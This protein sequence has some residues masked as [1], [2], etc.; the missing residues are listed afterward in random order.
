MA[1]RVALELANSGWSQ[2]FHF[3]LFLVSYI[4]ERPWWPMQSSNKEE[5]RKRKAKRRGIGSSLLI[6]D[7]KDGR[8]Q[9]SG[10]QEECKKFHKLHVIGMNVD[11]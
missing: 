1:S 5:R 3:F 2:V 9:D 6:L 4:E 11:L 7:L 10:K 8:L